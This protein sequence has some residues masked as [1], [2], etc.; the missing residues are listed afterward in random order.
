MILHVFN[1]DNDMA[2]A[3]GS[4]GYTPPANIQRMMEHTALLPTRWARPGEGVL[5]KDRVWVVEEPAPKTEDWTED[6]ATGKGHWIPVSACLGDVEEV[7]PW[8]WSPALC[9]RLQAVGIPARLM[10][11]AGQLATLRELSGRQQAVRMLR[12]V[13]PLHPCYVGQS[14]YCTSEEAVR[15]ALSRWPN[16]LLK[17]PWSSSGK[18]LRYGQ[19]GQEETLRGWYQRILTQQG[20]VVVEPLYD[21]L[22]DF[23]MEFFSDGEG[24]V[25][26]RGLSLFTTHSNG[27][28]KGNLLWPEARKMQ[29]MEERLA[30]MDIPDSVLVTLRAALEQRLSALVGTAYRGPLGVD[31]MLVRG[32][33]I[34][35]CVEINLRMTMGYVSIL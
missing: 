31:M 19:G 8:G 22:H 23:A 5:V 12:E 20:A 7:R 28:Y 25:T 14:V 16:T 9:H 6:I 30:E 13:Q 17:A 3:N 32:G 33:F 1:P 15:E 29:W 11:S 2:L 26:Y 34:H 10:P 18:G 4:P 24:H 27:A 35:P 21:K